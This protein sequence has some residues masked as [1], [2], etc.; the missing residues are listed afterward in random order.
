[1]PQ[2]IRVSDG[3]GDAGSRVEAIKWNDDG[4]FKEIIGRRPMV[5]CSLLVGSVT[6]RSFSDKDYWLTSPITEILEEDERDDGYYC[7]FKTLNS[8]YE[9]F[10]GNAPWKYE[11]RKK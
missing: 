7:K 4:T 10:A 11:K 6:A 9:F 5:G 2:L 8:I 3:A 1:M